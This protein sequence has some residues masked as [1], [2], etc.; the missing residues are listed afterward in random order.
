MKNVTKTIVAIA[1]GAAVAAP[2]FAAGGLTEQQIAEE[3]AN[4]H[5]DGSL[6]FVHSV[7]FYGAGRND[8]IVTVEFQEEL[9]NLYADGSLP[10]VHSPVLYGDAVS[11]S[12][13]VRAAAKNDEALTNIFTYQSW[14]GS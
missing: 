2:V 5:A 3:R 1:L 14:S 9:D 13:V 7:E 4:L 10:F 8:T 11:A 12:E 6:P